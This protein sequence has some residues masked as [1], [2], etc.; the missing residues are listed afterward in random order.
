MSVRQLYRCALLPVVMAIAIVNNAV[1]QDITTSTS[2]ATIPA[3]NLA[4]PVLLR[5]G[6][7]AGSGFF[8]NTA[9][10]TYLV[11]ANHVLTENPTLT[12]PVTHQLRGD[13]QLEAISY[14]RNSADT[15][16]NLLRL[17]LQDLQQSGRLRADTAHDVVVITIGE[18]SNQPS[19]DSPSAITLA[20]GVTGVE[21]AEQ[22]FVGVARASIR[23]LNEVLIGNDVVMFGYPTSLGI[24]QQRQQPPQ[25]VDRC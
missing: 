7:G 19:A 8:I 11:T 13:T 23:S 22:G 6:V 3:D 10:A 1:A 15:R 2:Y 24:P 17:N 16:R 4:Y 18:F 5:S 14:S 9:T 21:A 25:L 12:D 20:P